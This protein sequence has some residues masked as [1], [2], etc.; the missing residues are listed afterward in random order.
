[1]E[2][3]SLFGNGVERA[4]DAVMTRQVRWVRLRAGQYEMIVAKYA[5]RLGP[6]LARRPSLLFSYVK[7][8]ST[9]PAWRATCVCLE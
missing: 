4:D 9:T 2:Q 5:C 7:P 1:M 3:C 6:A 8:M